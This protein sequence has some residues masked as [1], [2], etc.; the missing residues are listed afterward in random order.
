M[1]K[2]QDNHFALVEAKLE[3]G[4]RPHRHFWEE[5]ESLQNIFRA[6]EGP[7]GCP[8]GTG[9]SLEPLLKRYH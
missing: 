2:M 5:N 7:S 6:L 4:A 1:Y 9:P 3:G 8:A